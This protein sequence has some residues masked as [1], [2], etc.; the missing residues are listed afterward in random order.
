MKTGDIAVLLTTT[1]VVNNTGLEE[2]AGIIGNIV[3]L[4]STNDTDDMKA[5][6]KIGVSGA[7]MSGRRGVIFQVALEW[8]VVY[9]Y[10]NGSSSTFC[11][12]KVQ[13]I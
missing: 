9:W 8:K 3:L 7:F 6:D 1:I 4:M 5:A 13:L 12:F 2:V 11:S 10:A